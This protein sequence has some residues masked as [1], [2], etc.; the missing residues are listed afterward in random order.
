MFTHKLV[1][2]R[3][4]RRKDYRRFL[5]EA[6]REEL[7]PFCPEGLRRHPNPIL[8]R[9]RAWFITKAAWRYRKAV[10]HFLIIS[11]R[12]KEDVLELSGRDFAEIKRLMHWVITHLNIKGGG[13]ALR[14][15]DTRFTG[16]TIRHLHF[17]F[18]V[19]RPGETPIR[20]EIGSQRR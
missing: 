14:F 1:D 19:P 12:H 20:F 8:H 18:L 4:A 5:L 11:R 10:R 16:A 9:S 17:H 6:E 13:I 2:P 7:C 15:G 3:H